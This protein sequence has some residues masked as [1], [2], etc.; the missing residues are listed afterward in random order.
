MTESKANKARRLV[1]S[2]RVTIVGK[3]PN[4]IEAVVQGDHDTYTVFVGDTHGATCQC[5]TQ[6]FRKRRSYECS[7]LMAVRLF[8]KENPE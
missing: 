7:H 2:D 6:R 1:D 5:K 8:L 4:W 3:T